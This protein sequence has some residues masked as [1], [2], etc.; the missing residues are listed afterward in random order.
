MSR[1][2]DPSSTAD[3]RG[4]TRSEIS[5][6]P[7]FRFGEAPYGV[8]GHASPDRHSWQECPVCRKRME[9]RTEKHAIRFQ[10]LRVRLCD[11]RHEQI[12]GRNLRSP[13]RRASM[14]AFHTVSLDFDQGFSFIQRDFNCLK[15][16]RQAVYQCGVCGIPEPE[17]DDLEIPR[18]PCPFGKVDILGPNHGLHRPC[19]CFN[20]IVGRRPEAKI[21][22]MVGRKTLG[23]QPSRQAGR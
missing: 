2:T 9:K 4:V 19:A 23:A 17:P 11:R 12:R 6:P 3:C 1:S 15:E 10:N 18:P 20:L 5:L 8:G 16:R 7:R 14:P 21:V 22:Y 13:A